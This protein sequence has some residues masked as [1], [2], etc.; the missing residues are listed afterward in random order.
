MCAGGSGI[1][2]GKKPP[3][4]AQLLMTDEQIDMI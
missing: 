4:S 3:V 2:T 1:Q